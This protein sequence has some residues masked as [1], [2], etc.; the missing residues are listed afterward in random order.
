LQVLLRRHFGRC[1]RRCLHLYI[2]NDEY[3]SSF[4]EYVY[5]DHVIYNIYV[6]VY[7]YVYTYIHTYILFFIYICICLDASIYL[8]RFQKS[9]SGNPTLESQSPQQRGSNDASM[10]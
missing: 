3:I 1:L 10:F 2:S 5:N 7:I 4:L 8:D 6:Y 9:D